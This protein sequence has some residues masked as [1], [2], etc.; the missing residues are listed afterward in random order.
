LPLNVTSWGLSS[1]IRST[2]EDISA[3]KLPNGRTLTSLRGYFNRY[4]DDA[5]DLCDVLSS[6]SP[7]GRATLHELC[8]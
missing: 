5:L 4:S 7:E 3:L 1:A 8:R 6:F 2:N